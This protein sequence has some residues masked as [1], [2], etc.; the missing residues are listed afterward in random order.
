MT[1]I[2]QNTLSKLIYLLQSEPYIALTCILLITAY[3]L[4][5]RRIR[6]QIPYTDL[7]DTVT[8]V[9]LNKLIYGSAASALMRASEVNNDFIRELQLA[10]IKGYNHGQEADNKITRFLRDMILGK[11]QVG[12]TSI[13]TAINELRLSLISH[14]DRL[15][16]YLIIA[17]AIYIFLPILTLLTL[18]ITSDTLAPLIITV[19]EIAVFEFIRWRLVKWIKT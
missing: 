6:A 15:E 18:A 2:I 1:A 11:E 8:I 17:N 7:L 14:I 12:L 3:I 13:H 16:L 19:V 5:G 10:T 9:N 4:S